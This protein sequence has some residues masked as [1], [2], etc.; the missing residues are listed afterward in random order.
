[1][2]F[3]W[4]NT[5]LPIAALFS[6]RMLGLFMLI[7]VFTVLAA[8]L[9]DSTPSLLGLALGGYGL[10]QGLLQIPFGMLSDR[11]GRKPIITLGLIFFISG[12]LLGALTTSIYGMIAARLLQG[13]GAIGAVLIAL[14]ADLTPN[15]QRTKAM[16]I[17]GMVIG[18]SFGLAMVLSPAITH[19]FGLSG[20]FYLTSGLGFLGLTLLYFCIPN[21]TQQTFHEESE[22]NPKLLTTVLKNRS[23]IPLNAGIFFQHLILTSTFYIIPLLLQQFILGGQLTKTWHFYLPL[24]V[25]SFILMMP[26]IVFSEKRKSTQLFFLTAILLTSISQF[27]LALSSFYYWGLSFIMLIYFIAFNFLEA[28]LPSLIS[29]KADKNT[30]G[31]ALGIYSTCQFLGIFF[32]GLLSGVLVDYWGIHAVFILNTFCSLIWFTLTLRQ[33]P[34]NNP[35]KKVVFK[36]N[37]SI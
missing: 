10:S 37:P 30:K 1:M 33:L 16:G 19:S 2:R 23:L 24:M 17:I 7:P 28:S 3:S 20:I 22:T 29:K 18:L 14:M 11:F 13:M 8:N 27:V 35:L 34:K 12:S 26:L 6:F 36:D 5:V 4:F 15:E 32:G 31:T 25:I 21:P 9:Q